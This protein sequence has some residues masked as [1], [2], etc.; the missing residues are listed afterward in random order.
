MLLNPYP[1]ESE[2]HRCMTLV[3]RK[4]QNTEDIYHQYFESHFEKPWER[5]VPVDEVDQITLAT[6]ASETK[7]AGSTA[8]AA[9]SDAHEAAA[10]DGAPPL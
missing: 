1:N 8:I 2:S 5:A 4:T 7:N 6:D 10:A 9:A 3:V